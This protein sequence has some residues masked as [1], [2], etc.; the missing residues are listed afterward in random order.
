MSSRDGRPAGWGYFGVDPVERLTC[1]ADAVALAEDCDADSGP[2]D[3]APTL[4]ALEGLLD[5]E[6][7]LRGECSVPYPCGAIGW[8]SYDVVR[9][10][11]DLPESAIDDRSLPQ[12][13]VASTTGWHHGRDQPSLESR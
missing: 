4:A 11:E 8:L 13:E 9:E 6:S 7:L 12:L 1:S 2:A 3:T 10:L 5:G